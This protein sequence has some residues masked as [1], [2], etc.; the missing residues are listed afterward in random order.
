MHVHSREYHTNGLSVLYKTT[1]KICTRIHRVSTCVL[2]TF[3]FWMLLSDIKEYTISYIYYASITI[4]IIYKSVAIDRRRC[5]ISIS[6]QQKIYSLTLSYSSSYLQKKLEW[7][8]I[9]FTYFPLLLLLLLLALKC[10]N[11]RFKSCFLSFLLIHLFF[12]NWFL[13]EQHIFK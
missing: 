4:S 6:S 3:A 13:R 10:M 9:Q 11:I 7:I 1:G 8:A 2:C 5:N 12:E